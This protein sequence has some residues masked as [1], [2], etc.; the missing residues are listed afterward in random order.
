MFSDDFSSEFYQIVKRN[1]IPIF[2]YLP[3]KTEVEGIL[4]NLQQEVSRITK[5]DEDFTKKTQR[6]KEYE[7]NFKKLLASKFQQCVKG[8]THYDEMEFIVD[9]LCSFNILKSPSQVNEKI[10]F[11]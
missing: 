7:N 4:P 9:V 1:V 11:Y 3:Q 6:S 5:P 10:K 8:S 2:Y